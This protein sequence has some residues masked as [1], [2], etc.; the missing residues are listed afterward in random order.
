[1][2]VAQQEGAIDE[3]AHA[4]ELVRGDDGRDASLRRL[5]HGASDEDGSVRRRGIVD[6]HEVTRRGRGVRQV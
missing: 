6:E 3:V 1:M 5:V 4:G 2:S